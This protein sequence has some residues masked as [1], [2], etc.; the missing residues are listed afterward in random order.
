MIR[1]KFPRY[2]VTLFAVF[3]ATLVIAACGGDGGGE[4]PIALSDSLVDDGRV[5]Y[6]ANCA[7]CHGDRTT[8][9]PLQGAPPH[10]ADGHTW[11]HP[12]RLLVEWVLDGV[13]LAQI[14]PTFRD[15]LSEVE[16]R[17]AIAYIKTF[18]PAEVVDMQIE[19]SAQYEKQVAVE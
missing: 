1:A 8:R 19:N 4:Y 5:V 13:P 3:T 9:P 2:F 12:D 7:V 14:M 10:T 11:H 6:E 18:W 17:S 16:A 15:T